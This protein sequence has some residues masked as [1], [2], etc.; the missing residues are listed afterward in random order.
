MGTT[1]NV[2][3]HNTTVTVY[4]V[5]VPLPCQHLVHV[6]G[7]H[8]QNPLS[9]PLHHHNHTLLL[10][11]TC[12]STHTKQ[13]SKKRICYPLEGYT[14]PRDHRPKTIKFKHYNHV[15]LN[16]WIKICFD[17][18]WIYILCFSDQDGGWLYSTQVDFFNITAS[19]T[20][21]CDFSQIYLATIRY[22]ISSLSTDFG[23][24]TVT[25]FW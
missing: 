7:L 6:D 4:E 14:S 13:K 25:I 18:W 12:S 11:Q 10:L 2:L 19:A 24:S 1:Q 17:S 21:F 9:R 5:H 3:N 22:H 15:Y 23:I 8:M 20:K 16:I